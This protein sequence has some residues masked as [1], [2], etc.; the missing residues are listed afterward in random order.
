MNN[1]NSVIICCHDPS[2][3]DGKCHLGHAPHDKSSRVSQLLQVC[4]PNRWP[5]PGSPQS[6]E[7]VHRGLGRYN[8]WRMRSLKQALR[9]IPALRLGTGRQRH[10]G[11]NKL[12]APIN[13]RAQAP[14]RV[15]EE[16]SYRRCR[17]EPSKGP[18]A[19]PICTQSSL[20]AALKEKHT[21]AAPQDSPGNSSPAESS[22]HHR[23]ALLNA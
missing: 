21:Q 8:Y 2:L 22:G 15:Y 9:A 7:H 17:L 23:Q 14:P 10:A 6:A 5:H 1:E 13:Q 19:A 3:P 16:G 4:L 18:G 20:S 11:C 12:N